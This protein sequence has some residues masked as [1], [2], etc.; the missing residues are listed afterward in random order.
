[1]TLRQKLAL[2]ARLP[3]RALAG[4]IVLAVRRRV[5]AAAARRRDARVATSASDRPDGELLPLFDHVSLAAAHDAAETIRIAATLHRRHVFD[6]LGSGWREI[7]HGM[8]CDG[9]GDGRY[10]PA[11]PVTADPAGNW[12]AGRLNPAN[13]AT[14]RRIWG[15]VDPGYVPI[16]WQLDIKSGYRWRDGDWAAGTPIGHLPG[17]DVKVPWE[18]ARMQHLATLAWAYG[19][20]GEDGAGGGFAAEFRNQILDFI[21]TNPP[22]FGVNWRSTMDVAI[23]AANWVVAHALFLAFGARFD[24]GFTATLAASL[25]D[26][27]RHVV[28]HLEIYPEGRGNHYLADICG[29]AFIA[30]VLPRSR[31]C[32]AWLAFAAQ[33]MRAETARQFGA[34]GGNFEGSTCYHRLSAEMVVFTTALLHGL[35]DD[36]RAALREA[37]PHDL[38]CRPARRLGPDRALPGP[39]HGARIAAMAEFTH[40]VTKPNGLVAQIGDNDSGRFLKLHPIYEP[41]TPDAARRRYLDLEAYRGLPEDAVFL[42][43]VMLDHR[44]L[45]A[46]AGALLGRRDFGGPGWLDAAVV[47]A[48][49]R[50]RP[51]AATARPLPLVE[52]TADG[53]ADLRPMRTIELVA[54]G[55]DLRAGLAL[56]AF[57]EFGLWIFRSDRLF[58]AVR[59]GKLGYDGRGAHDHNDQLGVELMIDGIDWIADPGSY[60]YTASRE[61]RNAYRSVKA[62]F[63]PRCGEREPGRLDLGD[64]WL[65]NEAKACCLAFGR[66]GFVGEHRGFGAPVRR[67]IA[68]SEHSIT[69]HDSGSPIGANTAS[70]RCVGRAEFLARFPTDVP[71]SPGYG[72]RYRARLTDSA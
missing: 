21:A 13:L 31:E 48:L 16:D 26:H 67:R 35:G 68:L 60:L 24:P 32:D 33:E 41:T 15:L 58:L 69:I 7:R 20:A 30:A 54:P 14:G 29:L 27:G 53:A 42:D 40:A 4:R 37:S 70:V 8:A 46:A 22:R 39:E 44:P 50:R 72:K 66:E 71:F 18:L 59:C 51:I 19:L 6:I 23:R 38:R 65:G 11:A 62:H 56:A 43:E 12:L 61:E 64:F 2:A 49:A 25:V 10:P 9:L 63:A 45:I 3:P 57:P 17:V 55:G 5:D 1:V 47:A 28:G 36:K 34:D 52:R